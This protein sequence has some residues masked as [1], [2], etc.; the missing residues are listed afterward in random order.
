MKPHLLLVFLLVFSVTA[1]ALTL[2]EISAPRGFVGDFHNVL[3][4]EQE[5]TLESKIREINEQT[6]VEVGVAI[7]DSTEGK[8]I[9]QLAWEIGNKWRI[10]KKDVFNGVLILV[11]V[12]DR[13]WFIATAKGIEGTLPDIV[14]NRIGSENFPEN[15]S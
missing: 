12:E 2:D 15:F 5:A 4:T 8:P 7:I 10:G 6:T 14:V 3:S 13:Q 1:S 11:V 9:E